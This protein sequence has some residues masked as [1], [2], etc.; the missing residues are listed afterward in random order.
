[1]ANDRSNFLY[2]VLVLENIIIAL[3]REIEDGFVFVLN[4][5]R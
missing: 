4:F 2:N 3:A 1:M 5:P